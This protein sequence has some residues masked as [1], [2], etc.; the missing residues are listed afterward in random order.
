[1]QEKVSAKKVCAV[2]AA[3]FM[4]FVGILTETSL[5]VTFPTLMKQFGVSLDVIQ[6]ITTGYLLMIAIIMLSSSYQ[7]TRF[8]AKQLFSAA[9]ISFIV[10]S[11]ISAF[12]TSF[13]IMLI[14]RLISAF[15]AGL[16][17]PLMFNLIVEIMPRQKWGFY[18]GIAGLVIAMAPTLGPA[19]GGAIT[20][21]LSWKWI[22]ISV[23]IFALIVFIFGILNIQKYHEVKKSSLDWMSYIVLSLAL[24]S[25][26]IGLNQI[27]KGFR[28]PVL[29]ILLISAIILFVL[30]GYLSKKSDKKLL[31]LAVFKQKAFIYGALAYFLLQFVN[32][33]ASFVLP[34]YAQIVGH[35]T[36]LIG[37]LILL[38]GSI[39]SG[40]LNPY[41]GNLYDRVGAKIPLYIGAS[42]ITL[43]CLLFAIWGM[44][45][46]IWMIIVIYTLLTLGHR[47]SFSNTMA[48]ALKIQPGQLHAD[49]TAV[50]Q[51]SQQLAGSLGTTIL[52]AIIAISQNKGGASYSFL[53]AQGSQ[54]AFYFTFILGILILVCDRRMLSLEKNK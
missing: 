2:L 45:L 11:L 39:V 9:C 47:M 5:N 53:T 32:I 30:Y 3:A 20:Y 24:I 41:F 13:S 6:W 31:D 22:F 23:S 52:A 7:N 38:P 14:G 29:W 50:C 36:S 46:K 28:N 42:L 4:S 16:S 10:G 25:L 51:T 49:A 34:N 37:G 43:S 15:G 21:Y 1:M 48:E 44:N 35:Q 19:F 26:V 18:M 17:T 33:G 27:S 40:L 54:W 12:S 8:S